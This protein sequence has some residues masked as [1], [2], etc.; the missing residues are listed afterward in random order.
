MIKLIVVREY[1]V[2][3]NKKY[4]FV[5]GFNYEYFFLLSNSNYKN[6]TELKNINSEIKIGVNN[7][8]KQILEVLFKIL[9]INNY[10]FIVEDNNSLFNKL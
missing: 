1:L 5:C 3:N 9:N 8:D 2:N 4:K 6:F 10:K 7:N